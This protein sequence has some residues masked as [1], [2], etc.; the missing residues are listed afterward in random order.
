MSLE[1]SRRAV[2]GGL[3]AS[4][5][6]LAAGCA[7]RRPD[8]QLHG[9]DV[10]PAPSGSATDSPTA[11][12]STTTSS[13]TPLPVPTV[14][15]VAAHPDAAWPTDTL[16]VTVTNGTSTGVFLTD[17][18][19]NQIRGS[20]LGGVFTPN[21][22]LLPETTYTAHVRVVD[23]AGNP[24]PEITADVTTLKPKI[25]ASYNLLYSGDTCGV[26]TPLTIQ[27]DSDVTTPEQRM[28][29]ERNLNV[30]TDPFVAGAWGWVSKRTAFWRP[31]EYW[32]PGTTA[33]LNAAIGGVQTGP[34]KWVGQDAT[35]VYRFEPTQRIVRVDRQ[36]FRTTL[37]ENGA[38]VNDLPCTTGKAGWES[39]Q[40]IKPIMQKTPHITMT[41]DFFGISQDEAGGYSVETYWDQ[42][43]TFSGEYIHSN[44]WSAY[45]M[46]KANV[47]HACV[48]LLRPN[49][50]IVW[51]FTRIGTPVESSASPRSMELTN[52]ISCWNF[53]LADW[54]K[55]S[56]RFQS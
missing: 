49:A 20:L 6:V 25:S 54:A 42:L 19:G 40:G 2:L 9:V 52:G 46:G 1:L 8:D 47:S 30:Q 55:Y 5:G 44:D 12:T 31:A 13:A 11:P 15:V 51:D 16:T 56:A 3:A 21:R 4:A 14:T 24:V 28:A 48:G 39:R 10:T 18:A 33:T 32:Q 36:K 38:L 34:D 45:A 50:K 43:M 23:L 7:V 17:P 37:W 22:Q 53:S 26:G 41:S 29:I 27:F 35:A